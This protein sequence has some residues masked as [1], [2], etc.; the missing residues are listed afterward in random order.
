MLQGMRQELRR[1][2]YAQVKLQ[3]PPEP[4]RPE[5]IRDQAS[6]Q[7]ILNARKKQHITYKDACKLAE[8]LK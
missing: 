8:K 6:L 3:Y 4:V 2:G 5:P 7:V 1:L